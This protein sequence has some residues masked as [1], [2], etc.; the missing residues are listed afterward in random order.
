MSSLILVVLVILILD[1]IV[2]AS[3]A[4]IFSVP[5]NRAKMHAEKS[6]SGKIL[7]SLK[8]SMERPIVT[9]ISL[10][11]LITII[12]S[13]ITGIMASNIFS[14]V[15]VGIFAAILTLFIMIF[16]EIIPKRLG[17][18][19]PDAIALTM[20]WP[21]KVI[22]TIFTPITWFI[23]KVTAPFDKKQKPFTSEEEI[24]FLAKMGT[25]EGSIEQY[26]SELIQKVFKLKDIT[27]GDMMTPKSF[28]FFLNG[29]K[30]LGELENEIR[31]SK[32]SRIPIYD[33]TPN[34]I[35]G[36]AYQKELLEALIQG[37]RDIQL[38]EF[39]QQPLVVPEDKLGDDLLRVFKES[40]QHLAIVIDD[41]G[42]VV[43]VVGLEDILEE[44]VGE[45]AEAK[46]VSPELIKRL[47]RNEVLAH[48]ETQI[49]FL[50][51]FFNTTIK[52][53]ATLNG[54]LLKK[55][56]RLPKKGEF[57]E[58]KNLKFVVEE[59]GFSAIEK[60]RVIKKEG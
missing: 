40:K 33:R 4:A 48:G 18:R 17:E 20:A 27:A 36:I 58:D 15:G 26:E 2:S 21:I 57:Y 16:A 11:N 43:G 19:F 38:K 52:A 24:T 60:V 32:H 6:N 46:D 51:H 23:D 35:L 3:E 31:T 29:N 56:G 9:L 10:S 41:H 28:V 49:A 44:L 8:E 34:Q 54:Y 30:T 45:I 1:G 5:L 42:N 47:S 50:N 7:L 55:F 14:E 12:G 25:K 53:H 22:S 59:V 13:M 39:A 37:K